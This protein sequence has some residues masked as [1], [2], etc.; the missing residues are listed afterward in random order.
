MQVCICTKVFD[1]NEMNALII[2]CPQVPIDMQFEPIINFQP[3][4]RYS[5]NKRKYLMT[6]FI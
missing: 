3:K 2:S 4:H 1:K 5:Y 6:Q